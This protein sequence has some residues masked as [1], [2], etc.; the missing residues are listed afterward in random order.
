VHRSD[1]GLMIGYWRRP[2]EEAEV[3]RGQWFTG[4]DAGVLDEEGYITHLGRRND[5]MNAGGFRVS[6]LEVEQ[7]LAKHP[8]VAEVAVTEISVRDGVSIIAA[9]IVPRE[10]VE[11]GW[12]DGLAGFAHQSLAAYKCPK[13][14]FIVQS[15]PGTANGKVMRAALKQLAQRA[16]KG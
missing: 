11:T 2:Q 13:E 14:Y 7:Q 1:P 3:T 4:G 12:T 6:P 5:L 16:S 9:F 8:G 15:L 10:T